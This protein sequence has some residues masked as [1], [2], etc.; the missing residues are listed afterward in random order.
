MQKNVIDIFWQFLLEAGIHDDFM[1]H[2]SDDRPG[3]TIRVKDYLEAV[4]PDKVFTDG[5]T[6][7]SGD[8][9][10]LSATDLWLDY[11]KEHGSAH[12]D[13]VQPSLFERVTLSG[14]KFCTRCY[15]LKPVSAFSRSSRY[16]DGYQGYCGHC[17]NSYKKNSP[18][19]DLRPMSS[20]ECIFSGGRI[21]LNFTL[22]A[23]LVKKAFT[24]C[25]L[26]HINHKVFLVFFS[27]KK[28]KNM[29]R[30][31]N[32]GMLVNEPS[33]YAEL[34][35]DFGMD[36]DKHYHLHTSLNI[37]K[38]E[39][40]VTVEIMRVMEHSE[41]L[42]NPFEFP[43]ESVEVEVLPSASEECPSV[44]GNDAA[45]DADSEE[46]VSVQQDF[47][48]LPHDEKVSMMMEHLHEL[49]SRGVMED[50]CVIQ[51]GLASILKAFDWKL[52][53][54]VRVVHYEDF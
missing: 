43:V 19:T 41:F 12:Q 40:T 21:Y 39:S 46:Q 17:I 25:G 45:E 18:V 52:Q 6:I 36:A 27:S 47:D 34:C 3:A 51:E 37:S 38:K 48:S 26:R 28:D 29:R 10:W 22:A 1:R 2:F 49:V 13:S 8:D 35:Q 20:Y 5:F 16:P 32:G 14:Y 31:A 23:L 50:S 53:R 54:P 42:V 33:L 30:C 4:A 11:L 44:A 15:Q 24:H 9:T 7:V